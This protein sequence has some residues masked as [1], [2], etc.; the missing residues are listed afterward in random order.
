MAIN[1]FTAFFS[2][3]ILYNVVQHVNGQNGER[4]REKK[5]CAYLFIASMIVDVDEQITVNARLTSYI[6]R[7]TI[8]YLSRALSLFLALSFVVLLACVCLFF[9]YVLLHTLHTP[10][11]FALFPC[12]VLS[13]ELNLTQI[14]TFSHIS[15]SKQMIPI[16]FGAPNE[17]PS[18][19]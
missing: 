7:C 13:F 17:I 9:Q 15:I 11:M 2:P 14:F 8:I 12:S 16:L 5:L 6:Q 1:L 19:I 18:F 4:E 3:F 10:C